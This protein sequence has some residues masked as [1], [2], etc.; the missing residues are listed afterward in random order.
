VE[1]G[2]RV[3]GLKVG[4]RDK[5]G[6]KEGS[7]DGEMLGEKVWEGLRVGEKSKQSSISTPDPKSIGSK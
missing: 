2:E 1:E 5:E 4:E 7:R 3:E 6:L